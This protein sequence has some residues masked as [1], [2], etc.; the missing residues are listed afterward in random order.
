MLVNNLSIKNYCS[1]NRHSYG[2]NSSFDYYSQAPHR[3]ACF[4]FI[5]INMK[6]IILT[7][8]LIF[9]CI[10]GSAN[11]QATTTN[12]TEY[13]LLNI[14][15]Q[16]S[17][18]VKCYA[19]YDSTKYKGSYS[20]ESGLLTK[21]PEGKFIVTTP[22][23]VFYPKDIYSDYC[24]VIIPGNNEKIKIEKRDRKFSSKQERA[25]LLVHEPSEYL[26]WLMGLPNFK[27]TEKNCS[28]KQIT[29]G[30]NIAIL[31]YP[32]DS[33]KN[34]PTI[35]R[36]KILLPIASSTSPVLKDY[37]ST[38]IKMKYGYSGGIAVSLDNNCYLGIVS[39]SLKN[40]KNENAIV[41][42]INKFK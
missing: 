1:Q 22:K 19:F 11:A 25:G 9:G 16:Y 14:W 30:T 38:D 24:E 28:S 13:E 32:K 18:R 21:T 2:E 10:L 36:G 3:G 15:R 33:D 40:E 39:Y 35:A 6:K 29:N 4:C 8:L 37:I 7:F 42:N 23:Y 31:G 20:D 12:L 34:Q 41:L 5:N 26:K 17:V 27:N